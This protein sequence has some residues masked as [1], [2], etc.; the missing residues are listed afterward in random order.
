MK[1]TASRLVT[2]V[3]VFLILFSTLNA[4]PTPVTAVTGYALGPLSGQ[5][6]WNGGLSGG[7]VLPFNVATAGAADV[8]NTEAHTGSHSW[9]FARGSSTPGAGTPFSPIVTTAGAPDQGASGDMVVMSFAFKAGKTGDGSLISIYEGAAKRD[10]RTGA[11][12]YLESTAG[13]DYVRLYMVPA[14]AE[15]P[16]FSSSNIELGHY[17]AADWHV[18]EMTTLYPNTST[19][20]D[21]IASWGVTTYKVDGVTVGKGSSWTHWWRY[22]NGLDAGDASLFPY[23]PGASFKFSNSKNDA[24]HF[25]FYFDDLSYRVINTITHATVAAFST[26]FESSAAHPSVST[27]PVTGTYTSSF[28]Q[29]VVTFD[30]DIYN[31]TGNA[32]PDD[33]TNPNNYLLFTAGANSTFDTVEC[34]TG[35]QGDD[36]PVTIDSVTYS[37]SGGLYQARLNLNS[38]ANL[39]AGSYRVLICGTTSIVNTDGIP[40]NDEP[41]FDS[42]YDFTI[43]TPSKTGDTADDDEGLPIPETGFAPST[44][45]TLPLQSIE[46]ID[47]GSLWLEIPVLGVSEKMVGVPQT[48][49]GW[50]VSWL[51]NNIGWLNGTAWPSW[52]GNAVLTAHNYGA[53]GLPG[54]F[55]NLASLKWGDEVILHASDDIYTYEVREVLKVTADDLAAVTKHEDLPWLTLVT[56][57]GYD[58]E[59]GAYL[60]RVVVRAVLVEK[61]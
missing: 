43:R 26:S 6:G 23:A 13:S 41:G 10:D 49:S 33:V 16:Y 44:I 42:S 56:C 55:V 34:S 2:A 3:T 29:I 36:A 15:S 38:G 45:T 39:A 4:R 50:D 53:D 48:P 58:E 11:N 60:Y 54:P 24:S 37:N 17:S 12:I 61:E 8:V 5:N 1:A 9:Y 7:A 20:P 35:I 22:K 30:E 19:E 52:I 51:G 40:L 47:L 18:V 31:P 25:G 59:S 57:S 21:K 46:Y 28:N 32:L 14:L 27:A